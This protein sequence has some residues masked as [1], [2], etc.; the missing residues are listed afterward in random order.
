MWE[1][2]EGQPLEVENH[3]IFPVRLQRGGARVFPK[4]TLLFNIYL[5]KYSWL[6]V[7]QVCKQGDSVIC[8]AGDLGPIPGLGRSPGEGKGYPLQYSCLENSMDYHWVTKSW[9]QLSD[10]HFHFTFI[11]IYY[12]WDYFPYRLSQDIDYRSLCYTVNLC[13]SLHIYF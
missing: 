11:R 5:L 1:A 9:A 3:Q 8:N 7:F 13:C 10:F 4:F 6:T 12:C 2:E